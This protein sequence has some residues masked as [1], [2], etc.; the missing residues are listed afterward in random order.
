MKLFQMNQRPDVAEID[1]RGNQVV[2]Q[3]PE[4]EMLPD[5]DGEVPQSLQAKG[6]PKPK[7]AELPA[8]IH[9]HTA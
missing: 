2:L 4:T 7:V 5:E 6:K 1:V 3:P 8:A 9:A